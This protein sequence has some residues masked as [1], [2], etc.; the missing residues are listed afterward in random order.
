MAFRAGHWRARHPVL[1]AALWTVGLVALLVLGANASHAQQVWRGGFGGFTPPRYPTKNSFSGN[2]TFCRLQ[3]TSNRREKL[4]PSIY[5][6]L[7][8][9]WTR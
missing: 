3:F 6:R 8:N 7:P 5:R 1:R 4:R 2:F 9:G